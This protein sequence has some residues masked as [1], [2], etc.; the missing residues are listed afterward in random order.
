MKQE[1]ADP[2]RRVFAQ[3]REANIKTNSSLYKLDPFLDVDGILRV[4]GRLDV[5]AWQMTLS[6]PLSCHETATSP[7]WLSSIFMNVHIIKAKE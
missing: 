2:G 5:Q 7:S 1:K 4:G 6:F 3:Q